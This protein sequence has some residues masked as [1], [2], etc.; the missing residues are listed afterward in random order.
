M[1]DYTPTKHYWKAMLM[2]VVGRK[3]L[4]L[5]VG[6]PLSDHRHTNPSSITMGEEVVGEVLK[7]KK[8]WTDLSHN[9]TALQV[10]PRDNKDGRSR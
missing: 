9:T 3:R 2:G 1:I 4:L 8:Y 5:Y 6:S 7:R 10:I